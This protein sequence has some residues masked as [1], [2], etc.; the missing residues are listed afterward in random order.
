MKET[1]ILVLKVSNRYYS[2]RADLERIE[3]MDFNSIQAIRDTIKG[4]SCYTLTDFMD[5]CNDTD[6]DLIDSSRI[7]IDISENWIGYVNLIKE[8]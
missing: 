1:I 6:D 5:S 3:G 4:V 7:N 2:N 8:I